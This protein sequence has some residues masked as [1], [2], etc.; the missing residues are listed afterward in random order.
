MY[1]LSLMI[2]IIGGLI[3]SA[4]S[5]VLSQSSPVYYVVLRHIALPCIA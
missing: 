1:T 3:T 5:Y 2:G 4:F